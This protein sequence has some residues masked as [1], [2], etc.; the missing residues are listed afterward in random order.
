M[1]LLCGHGYTHMHTGSWSCDLA[2]QAGRVGTTEEA[3]LRTLSSVWLALSPPICHIFHPLPP[4]L[5]SLSLWK[6]LAISLKKDWQMRL[7]RRRNITNYWT[8]E[9]ISH[10]YITLTFTTL[11]RHWNIIELMLRKQ[12]Q[13]V[14]FQCSISTATQR[15]S[16]TENLEWKY[17]TVCQ[18][19]YLSICLG[20]SVF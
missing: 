8:N 6:C 10:Y 9:Y 4:S 20:L 13:N 5:L 14:L 17:S 7:S 12:C 15:Y 2:G 18:Y 3:V 1:T 19:S 11:T 16:L